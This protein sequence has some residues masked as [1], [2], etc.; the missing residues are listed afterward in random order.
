MDRGACQ[1][2]VSGVTRTGHDLA[3]K[4]PPHTN[5]EVNRLNLS[6]STFLP[7]EYH[8]DPRCFLFPSSCMQFIFSIVLI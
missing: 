2:T 5:K 7:V 8:Y 6:Q 1:A 4:P 3:T